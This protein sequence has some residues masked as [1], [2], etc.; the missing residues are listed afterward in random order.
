MNRI[1]VGTAPSPNLWN[2]QSRWGQPVNRSSVEVGKWKNSKTS[3]EEADFCISL[4][5]T[6]YIYETRWGQILQ[7]KLL[8]KSRQA[9]A[10][11]AFD[12]KYATDQT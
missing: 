5:C 7:L 1:V 6:D 3:L 4:V 10:M 9:E 2:T 12:S 8:H 11:K